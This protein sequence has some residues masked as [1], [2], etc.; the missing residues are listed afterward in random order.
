MRRTGSRKGFTLVELMVAMIVTSIIMSAVAT[1]AFAFSTA[2]DASSDTDRKQAQIRYATQRIGELIRHCKLICAVKNGDLV[3]WR[4]DNTPGGED[5]I[6]PGEL[7]YI[8]TD[9]DRIRILD[10]PTCPSWLVGALQKPTVQIRILYMLG[11]SWIKTTL[12]AYCDEQYVVAIPECS[13]VQFLFDASP[14]QSK[15]V[16]ISFELTENGSIRQYHIDSAIRCWAGHQIS[17]DGRG[18]ID[19]DD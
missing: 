19:D 12:M 2:N 9:N 10:F 4:D 13:N 8:E 6:D 1:L 15:F 18:I 7:V 16:N 3:I 11:D 17:A 14:P 5:K